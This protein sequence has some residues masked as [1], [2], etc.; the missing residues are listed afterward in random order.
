M[1][2]GRRWMAALLLWASCVPAW[3]MQEGEGKK[4]EFHFVRLEYVDGFSLRRRF[5]RGW[6]MQDWPEADMH[7][8]Q[9]IQRLT[10]IDTGEARHVPLT[11]DRIYEYPWAYATQV[12]YWQLS[13]GEVAR[14]R[15][16]LE[17]G[18]FL[19]VDDFHGPAEWEVF[20]ETM[21]R[22]LPG[23]A[24]LEI[25]P[26]NAV[27]HVL[28]DIVERVQIPGLRHLRRGADGGTVVRAEHVPPYWR[29]MYDG[30]GRMV[31]AIHY[32]QDVGDA[33]EHADMPEYPEAMTALAYRFGLN[34][35][36]YA[37]TH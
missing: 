9:G 4:K 6:W 8:T 29:A 15:D 32:N 37:M 17:R 10:R 21:A 13:D 12:G 35:I 34:H 33:W 23:Q 20:R 26:G 30:K 27:L 25:E 5:G 36:I 18:G 31:V 2:R 16:Y 19:V 11:D 28:Y 3:W 7:F 24:I 22:V 14:L 1:S